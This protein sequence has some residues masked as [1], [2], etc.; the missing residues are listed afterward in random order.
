M[1]IAS[2]SDMLLVAQAATAREAIAMYRQEL[3]DVV[4]MD[5]RLPGASGTD[6]LVSIRNEFPHARVMML[7]TSSGDAEIQ[8]ALRAG[9]AAYVLKS[10]AKGELL[11]IIRHVA[12]GRNPIAPS[13]K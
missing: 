11:Q 7:T 9:A 8:R 2:Q 13:P 6:A 5:H 4:L 12:A 3:P 10:V 1:I